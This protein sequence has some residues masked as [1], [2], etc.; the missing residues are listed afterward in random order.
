MKRFMLLLVVVT[1]ASLVM[2]APASAATLHGQWTGGTVYGTGGDWDFGDGFVLHADPIEVL[3][4]SGLV[5][6]TTYPTSTDVAGMM[7]GTADPG[8]PP[9]PFKINPQAIFSWG[10]AVQ[11]GATLTV[12]GQ[13]KSPGFMKFGLQWSAVLVADTASGDLTMTITTTGSYWGWQTWVLDGEL[14]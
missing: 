1:V 6:I 14:F 5:N 4:A 11:A 3:G 13:V 7:I 12:A 8:V 10:P 2:V 9:F